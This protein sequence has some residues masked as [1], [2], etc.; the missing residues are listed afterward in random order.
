MA[1]AAQADTQSWSLDLQ[2]G[3]FVRGRVEGPPTPLDLRHADG[4]PVR[5]LLAEGEGRDRFMFVA[6][7]AGRYQLCLLYTSPSPRD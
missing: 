1:A 2:A 6:P 5:R 3:D 7:G 4:Q